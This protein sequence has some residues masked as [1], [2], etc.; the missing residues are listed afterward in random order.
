MKKHPVLLAGVAGT[1]VGGLM[2]GGITAVH[3]AGSQPPS[4]VTVTNTASNPVPTA[5][6]GTTVVAGTVSV[7]SPGTPFV[8]DGNNFFRYQTNETSITVKSLSEGQRLTLSS[9]TVS[10]PDTGSNAPTVPIR[11][12]IGVVSAAVVGGQY[13]VCSGRALFV[14]SNSFIEVMVPPDDSR[15]VELPMG[16][17]FPAVHDLTGQGNGGCLVAEAF[18]NGVQNGVPAVDVSAVGSVQ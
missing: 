16:A 8:A 6:Q 15:Q 4:P 18:D 7:A 12:M 10:L 13:Q 17:A 3:A 11:V 2:F 5:A 1:L 14:N 9:F